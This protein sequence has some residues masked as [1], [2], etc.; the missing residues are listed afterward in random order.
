LQARIGAELSGEQITAIH[1]ILSPNQLCSI[2]GLAGAGK[3]TLLSVAREAWERQGYRAHGAALAGKAADSL[4]SASGISSRT[5]ASLEA[6]WKSGYE[7][8]ACCDVVV[9]DEAGMVGTRQLARVVEQLRSRGCKLVLVGDPDQL[10]PIQAGTPFRDIAEV[11]G[12]A[13]LTEIRRQ[14]SEWQ[15]KASQDLARGQCHFS[16]NQNSLPEC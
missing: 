3:S 12:A 13:R 5:L 8:V 9:I 4:Q 14:T 7:P 11:T 2:V 1:Q 15:R 6:S 16:G 10:Q